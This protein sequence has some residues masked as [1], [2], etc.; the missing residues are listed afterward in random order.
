M[1][2]RHVAGCPGLLSRAIENGDGAFP[3]VGSEAS[4]VDDVTGAVGDARAFNRLML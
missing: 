4:G 3:A 1:A 2:A